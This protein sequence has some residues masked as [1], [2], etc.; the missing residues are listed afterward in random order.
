ML[1]CPVHLKVG[2]KKGKLVI[3]LTIA[4]Y[5][6]F[7]KLESRGSGALASERSISEQ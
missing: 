6:G 2:M 7:G 4:L 1:T 3:K 5:Y